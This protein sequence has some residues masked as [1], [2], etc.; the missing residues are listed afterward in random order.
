MWKEFLYSLINFLILFGALFFLT[1]KLI[2]KMFRSRQ[3][4]IR[5]DLQSADDARAEAERLGEDIAR[6]NAEGEAERSA[7]LTDARQRAGE[8]SAALIHFVDVYGVGVDIYFVTLNSRGNIVFVGVNNAIRGVGVS[9]F[10]GYSILIDR[11]GIVY[12]NILCVVE[13]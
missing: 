12:N 9:G 8:S 5:D 10:T 6:A 4:R 1:R 2:P 11:C 3:D 13:I 7:M